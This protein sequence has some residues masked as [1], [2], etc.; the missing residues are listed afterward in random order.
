MPYP[1]SGSPW[2]GAAASPAYAGVFIPE[3]WSGNIIEKFYD[4]SVVPAMSNTN[5]EGEIRSHG[6]KVNIRTVPTLTI[7]NYQAEQ[8]LAVQR[9][10][11]ALVV[12][13]IDQGKYFNAVLDDVM[14]VQSDLDLMSMWSQDASEQMKIVIDSDVLAGIW[15]TPAATT[16]RGATAGRISAGIDLGVTTSPIELDSTNVLDYIVD[17]GTVLDEANI[18]EQGRYFIIPSWVSALIKKSDLKDASLSGDGTSIL[19][20]GRIGMIDR[21]TLYTSNLLPT[22]THANLTTGEFGVYAGHKNA[23]TFASQLTNVET[24]RAESTFGTLMRGLQVFGYKTIDPTAMTCGVI[25]K[26]TS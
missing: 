3:I 18:P 10:S 8:A 13:N 19:R 23:L 12:L 22:S 4:A 21:F 9:P 1:I 11:S 5:Y 24:L 16:N 20:N 7:A 25:K 26:K 2:S 17:H 6:D 14:K 15:N